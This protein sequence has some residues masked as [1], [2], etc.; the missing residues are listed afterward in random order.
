MTAPGARLRPGFVVVVAVAIVVLLGIVG[1]V[2][3]ALFG[4]DDEPS[5]GGIEELV[6]VEAPATAP[7]G[8]AATTADVDTDTPGNETGS[9]HAGDAPTTSIAPE[10]VATVE[11]VSDIEAPP[12]GE[13]LPTPGSGPVEF[14][15]LVTTPPPP[16]T[17]AAVP[18]SELDADEVPELSG[19]IVTS[20]GADHVALTRGDEGLD[21]F[22]I[23]AASAQDAIDWF[24]DRT[25][26]ELAAGTASPVVLLGAPNERFVAVAGS[27]FLASEVDQQ[28]TTTVS[29]SVIGAAGSDG[30]AI[31][32]TVSRPESS[33]AQQLAADGELLRAILAH[34]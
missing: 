33:S 1:I 14:P 9:G 10:P 31:V 30:S 4:G 16:S 23:E 29:G 6:D 13:T 26:G 28:G 21:I 20:D 15:V 18:I 7:D 34:L 11:P 24:Y 8:A 32:L 27:Q 25:S 5:G 22:S 12:L 19:W 3:V 17:F 2:A